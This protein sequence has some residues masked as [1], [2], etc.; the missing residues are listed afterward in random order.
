[1]ISLTDKTIPLKFFAPYTVGIINGQNQPMPFSFG[2][3]LDTIGNLYVL[4]LIAKAISPTEMQTVEAYTIADMVSAV[5]GDM[6]KARMIQTWHDSMR[7]AYGNP[8]LMTDEF[9]QKDIAS[10]ML[11]QYFAEDFN[12]YMQSTGQTVSILVEDLP[13]Q[14]TTYTNMTQQQAEQIAKTAIKKQIA[15]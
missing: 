8:K 1:M 5:T 4:P 2:M 6:D 15:N 7:H 9:L 13:K 11:R 12:A 10:D 3:A 14:V